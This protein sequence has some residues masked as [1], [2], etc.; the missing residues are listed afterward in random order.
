MVARVRIAAVIEVSGL[1]RRFG[2]HVAVDDISFE[3]GQ[4]EVVGFL[5]LN[6]AGKTTTLRVLS[7]YL[8]ATKGA[9]KVAG[10]D[11]LRDS[12]EV[13]R[14]IGYLPENVPL[15]LEQRV[16]EMLMMQARLHG[17]SRAA[18]V[19]RIGEVLERVGVLDRRRQVIAGLSRGLR[20][21]VGL[22][23][24]LLHK[25][26]VLI[27]DEP[28]SGLDP[29]QRQEVRS[30]LSELADEHTVLLSSHILPEVEAVCPRTIIIDRGRIVAD[31]TK[32]ELVRGLG[33]GSC[34]RLEAFLGG[35]VE[36]ALSSLSAIG[37]VGEVR[38]LGQL[39]IHHVLEIEAVED[40]RE[41]V[42]ALAHIK[43]WA[44]RELSYQ[45]PTL[46][47]VFARIAVGSAAEASLP[48]RSDTAPASAAPASDEGLLMG[49]LP[50]AQAE[51]PASDSERQIYSLNPFDGGETRDLNKPTG[52]GSSGAPKED[53]DQAEDDES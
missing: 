50:M 15:Y 17:I 20:Q 49:A 11:V 3:V 29:V 47:Q 37:G 14:R 27:L 44:V 23:M 5:G 24:A 34:V 48:D 38:D 1:T 21:R 4:G 39:G 12:L 7:G 31:G 32:E 35:D 46:E 36:G 45:Q 28:T 26:E 2:A 25:P 6:G 43:G 52:S 33:R 13:R 16:E 51:D 9:A 41:D 40:L 42:G 22:A 18:R 19:A 8:P 30:L 53:C 10:F